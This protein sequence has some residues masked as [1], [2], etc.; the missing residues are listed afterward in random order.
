M[1]NYAHHFRATNLQKR[2]L[3]H[4]SRVYY[5]R[6]KMGVKCEGLLT[7]PSQTHT[8]THSC[9]GFTHDLVRTNLDLMCDLCDTF[10]ARKRISRPKEKEIFFGTKKISKRNFKKKFLNLTF[11]KVFLVNYTWKRN[12]LLRFTS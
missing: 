5:T 2:N 1:R 3:I 8:W 6:D 4:L 10:R 11:V 9:V 7:K 12:Y